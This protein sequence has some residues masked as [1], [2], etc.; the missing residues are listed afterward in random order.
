MNFAN[1]YPHA[2][3]MHRTASKFASEP[4]FSILISGRHNFLKRSNFLEAGFLQHYV[5]VLILISILNAV[6]VIANDR[7]H[8]TTA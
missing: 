5:D 3:P 6:Y 4:A 8:L 2:N 7:L 1:A